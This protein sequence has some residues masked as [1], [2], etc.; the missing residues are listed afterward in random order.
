VIAAELST[1]SNIRAGSIGDPDVVLSPRT[2][3][4]DVAAVPPTGTLRVEQRRAPLGLLVERVDGRPLAGPQGVVVTTPGNDVTER[5]SPGS[6]VDLTDAEALNRPP[7]DVLPAGREL[8]PADP[9]PA[10]GTPDARK[11]R[12]IV[13]HDD[14][15]LDVEV[16]GEH[17]DVGA[18]V[19]MSA[20]T[21]AARR[22]PV[23]SDTSAL[24]TA[25]PEKWATVAG[26]GESFDS[27]TAAHQFARYHDTLAVPAVDA[28]APVSLAGV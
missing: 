15:G 1:T 19:A 26:G 9:P 22:P 21:D 18:L 2:G 5:F 27:A 16:V 12:Q 4:P 11:V 24:V 23:L 17:L 3:P 25:H 10:G 13:I 20:M 14:P 6:Y 7:F 28:A 8:T